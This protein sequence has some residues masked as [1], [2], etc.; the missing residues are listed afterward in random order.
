MK[1]YRIIPALDVADLETALRLVCRTAGRASVYGYKLGFA[2]GLAYGLPE[3]V[4]RIR[5]WTDKPLIYDHQKAAT[6][7]PDTGAL[8]ADVLKRAGIDEAI[9]FRSSKEVGADGID[10]LEGMPLSALTGRVHSI[11]VETAGADGIEFFARV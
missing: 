1:E 5:E 11:G 8:F 3:T 7:I 6:D 9:L 4:R 10:A 2:L